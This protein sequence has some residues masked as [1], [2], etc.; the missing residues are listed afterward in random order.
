MTASACLGLF[1]KVVILFPGMNIVP[2]SGC[3]EMQTDSSGA[4][5][6]CRSRQA[7]VLFAKQD[8][9]AIIGNCVE[10][11]RFCSSQIQAQ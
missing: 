5:G 6:A 2:V 8:L 3:R 1:F 9:K 11:K 4:A 10:D 7:S